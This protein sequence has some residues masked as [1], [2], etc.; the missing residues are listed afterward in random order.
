MSVTYY[1]NTLNSSISYRYRLLDIDTD[2]SND[3][4]TFCKSQLSQMQTQ[5]NNIIKSNA[6]VDDKI[7]QLQACIFSMNM[8]QIGVP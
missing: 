3:K 5:V 8:D 7:K 2:I 1:Q 6:S 4:R